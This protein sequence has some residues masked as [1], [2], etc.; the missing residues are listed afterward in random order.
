MGEGLY[1]KFGFKTIGSYSFFEYKK[2]E[3]KISENIHRYEDKYTNDV[4]KLDL[5]ATSENRRELF[6]PFLKNA[7][8]YISET[9]QLEGFYIQG[10]GDGPI[11]ASSEK[12]GKALL[13]LKHTRGLFRSVIPTSNKTAI[14]HLQELGIEIKSHAN[15]MLLG[16]EMN[17]KP[18][19]I[20][21]RLAGYCG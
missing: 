6:E 10:F 3:S 11:I 17:W 12:A 14:D 2:I 1:T 19:T 20:Y 13:E 18:E 7:W 5:Q 16:K 15:R 9:G 4:F 21:S 8:V